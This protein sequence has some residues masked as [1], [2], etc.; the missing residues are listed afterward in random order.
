MSNTTSTRSLSDAVEA[1]GDVIQQGT[2]I[3]MDLLDTLSRNQTTEMLGKVLSNIAPKPS[4]AAK[5]G[6]DIPPPCWMPRNLGDVMSHVCLGGTATL[7]VRVSNCSGTKRDI[8]LTPAGKPEDIKAVTVQPAGLFLEP[9]Q[10]GVFIVSMPVAAT[11]SLGQEFE[12]LLWVRG[13]LDHYLRWTVRVDKRGTD[14]CHE[15]DV[16]DCPDYVHHW[17]DHFYCERPCL[18]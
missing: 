10:A 1:I 9:M 14:C 11:A 15:I 16:D 7:R 17:Y 2:R 4:R 13:C 3:G 8:R 12:I 18:R 5:C 6:C